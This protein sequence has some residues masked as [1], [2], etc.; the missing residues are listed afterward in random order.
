MATESDIPAIMDIVRPVVEIMNA[1]GNYQW[2]P[3]YPNPGVFKQ[4][5]LNKSL[6]VAVDK[7]RLLSFIALDQNQAPEYHGI[8]WRRETAALVMHR[9]AVAPD[10]G[11]RGIATRMEQFACEHTLSLGLDYIRTDTHSLN[12]VMQSFLKNRNF[13]FTGSLYFTKCEE[14]FYCYDKLLH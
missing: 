2:S 12:T 7:G 3:T 13:T 14:P 6:F 10:A 5:V 1:G 4:D 11:G 9:F 8:Q